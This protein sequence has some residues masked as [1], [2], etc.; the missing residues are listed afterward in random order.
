L[1][2]IMALTPYSLLPRADDWLEKP[3]CFRNQGHFDPVFPSSNSSGIYNATLSLL[4]VG[5]CDNVTVNV[6]AKADA[7]VCG[8]CEASILPPQPYTEFGWPNIGGKTPPVRCPLSPVLWLTALGRDSYWPV[9]I[10]DPQRANKNT[11]PNEP[12]P[13]SSMNSVTA[14][15][16]RK[17]YTDSDNPDTPLSWTLVAGATIVLALYFFSLMMKGSPLSGSDS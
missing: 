6:C 7:G 15:A 17:P 1:H 8:H 3:I 11:Q 4:P 5:T 9:A 14:A 13:R 10:L 16:W 12:E 2:G